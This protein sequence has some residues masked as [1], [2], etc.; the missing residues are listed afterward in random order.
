MNK[1]PLPTAMFD[2]GSGVIGTRLYLVAGKDSTGT[3]QKTLWIY[4]ALSDSWT[5]GP[6]MPATY[7]AVENPAVAAYNGKLYVFTGSTLPFSGAVP[8]TAVY[9]PGTNSWS[10]LANIPTARGGATAQAIG[11]KIYVAGGMNDLGASVTTLE[12]Y[13]PAMNTWAAGPA[14]GTPRDNPGSAALGGKLYIFGGRTRLSDGSEPQPTLNTTEM[15]D[16]GTNLWTARANMPTGRRTVAVGLLN[17]R[18]QVMGGERTPTGATFSQNEEYDPVTNTWTPLAPMIPTGRHG[19]GFGTIDGVVYV[20]AGGTTG[21]TA[22]STLN[23]AFSFTPQQSTLGYK[24][25][26]PLLFR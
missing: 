4:D 22:W 12:I 14:M 5:Q 26:L 2:Q 24:T 11:N 10:M 1:T 17:G 15:F 23:Q 7:P 20:V 21:G 19:A 3:P 16:P 13:D 18:A 8:N 25:Y 9:D 6:N